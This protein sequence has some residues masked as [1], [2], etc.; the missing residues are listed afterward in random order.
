VRGSFEQ[1]PDRR[2]TGRQPDPYD[3]PR[4]TTA[5]R[6]SG[7]RVPDLGPETREWWER[8]WTE[9]LEALTRQVEGGEG[10]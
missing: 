3:G 8:Y 1:R 10:N 9:A 4:H 6:P 5:P 7:E 2:L